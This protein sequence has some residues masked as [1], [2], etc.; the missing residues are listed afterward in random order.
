MIVDVYK[1]Q[2]VEERAQRDGRVAALRQANAGPGA[3]RN[4]G[5]ERACGRY[6]YCLD[7]D[8]DVYKRQV[9][10]L[11]SLRSSTAAAKE[12]VLTFSGITN[13]RLYTYRLN[14]FCCLRNTANP[15]TRV[16]TPQPRQMTFAPRLGVTPLRLSLIHI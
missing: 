8:E 5:L 3:A 14:F 11:S 1:R 15:M 12:E 10:R 4:A 9:R 13:L 2:I 7:A 6:V 16:A